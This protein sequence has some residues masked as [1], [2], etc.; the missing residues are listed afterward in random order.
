MTQQPKDLRGKQLEEYKKT[1]N[2]TSEQREVI[3]GTLLGDASMSLRNGKPCYNIKFEQG[4]E[5]ADYINHLYEIFEPFT[6]T[7]PAW[8]W[9]DKKK[10]RRARWFRTYRHDSFIYYWNLFYGCSSEEKRKIVPKNID[11]LITPRVLAYWFMDDGSLDTSGRCYYLH[12]QGFQRSESEMLCEVLKQKL[13]IIATVQKDK[14]SWRIYIRRESAEAFRTL[15]K[16]YILSC[17]NYRI[18][19]T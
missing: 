16:P 2:L 4:E 8:R 19:L 12:T 10:T 9:I 15:I 13:N 11:K 6:G 7:P 1:L 18:E 5:H 3:I 14:D 17:F